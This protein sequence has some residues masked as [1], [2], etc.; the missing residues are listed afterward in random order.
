MDAAIFGLLSPIQHYFRLSV[1]RYTSQKDVALASWLLFVVCVCWPV[2]LMG[3]GS[4][5]LSL[6]Q[7]FEQRG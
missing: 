2:R 7:W 6:F 1:K 5:E 3:W 4:V